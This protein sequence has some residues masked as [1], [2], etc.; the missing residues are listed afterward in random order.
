MHIAFVRVS[1]VFVARGRG[2]AKISG[3]KAALLASLP[4]LLLCKFA[5]LLL[6]LVAGSEQL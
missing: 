5:G 4:D 6:G 3:E 1:L 2:M